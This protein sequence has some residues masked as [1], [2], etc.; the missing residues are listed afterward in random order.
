MR[1]RRGERI[2]T[3]GLV[4][5]TSRPAIANGAGE[6]DAGADDANTNPE[7]QVAA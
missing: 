6:N 1:R 5:A 2:A 4:S 3:D 7:K